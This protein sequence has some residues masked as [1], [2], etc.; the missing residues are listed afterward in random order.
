MKI[1]CFNKEE[2]IRTNK[3]GSMVKVDIVEDMKIAEIILGNVC[4]TFSQL[5]SIIQ[6]TQSSFKMINFDD[7][8]SEQAKELIGYEHVI[9]STTNI[10]DIKNNNHF[11]FKNNVE[12]IWI[13][14]MQASIMIKK[15][16]IMFFNNPD[17]ALI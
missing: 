11:L 13:R 16:I 1:T 2:I 7:S 9:I 10:F 15:L 12:Y 17:L 14:S 3:I 4:K 6:S 5:R 8:Q